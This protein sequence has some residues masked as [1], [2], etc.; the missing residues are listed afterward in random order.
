MYLNI[1]IYI[2]EVQRRIKSQI[3][4]HLRKCAGN[5]LI[6]FDEVQKIVPGALEAI[7]PG[8]CI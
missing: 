4:I 2:G 7:V 6:I 8:K 3:Y 1:Y 5:G